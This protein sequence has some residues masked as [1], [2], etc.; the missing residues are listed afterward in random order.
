MAWDGANAG[1]IG[2]SKSGYI[3]STIARLRVRHGA[4]LFTPFIGAYLKSKFEYLRQTS[5][6]ATIPHINR[7]A[8]ESI[9]LPAVTYNDQI[10]IA[11]LLSKVEGLIAR[12]KQ[13]LAQLDAMLKGVFLEMFGDPVRNEKGWD[14]APLEQFGSINRGISKHRPRNDPQLLGGR[15]PLIQTGEVSNAG[16]YITAY[17]Q[18]Y[19]DIG[20]AQSKPWPAGTLCITIAANIAQTG[21]LT[22]D[23]C[24]PD[25]VVGFTADKAQSNTLYVLGLFWFFQAILEKNAP[26]AAQKNIN[27]E[28]LRGLEVPKPPVELQNQFA[29]AAEKIEALKSRY[30]QTLTDLETLYAALSQSAF[31]GELDLS[32]IPLPAAAPEPMPTEAAPVTVDLDVSTSPLPDLGLTAGALADEAGRLALLTAWLEAWQ[33]HLG[34]RPF[35]LPAFL[36]ATQTRLQTLYPESERELGMAAYEQIKD[37]VFAA[38]ASG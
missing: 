27:L 24:F 20:F 12:R 33:T 17:T 2:F 8:L 25:S 38:H 3:G 32:R 11:H 37:W 26:A 13:Q 21:I 31:K 14:K 30:Q 1:T 36:D 18:T 28:I 35:G 10:R 34:T 22:F 7:N 23:A 16:T 19:S 4:Q 9:P 29:D 6:G 15:H 5:T